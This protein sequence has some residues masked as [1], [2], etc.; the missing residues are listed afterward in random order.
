MRDEALTLLGN[1]P[2]PNTV[3]WY[4]NKIEQTAGIKLSGITCV[5]K[6]IDLNYSFDKEKLNDLDF[7]KQVLEDITK[8][9]YDCLPF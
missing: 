7:L 6:D 9:G 4:K 8:N 5:W 2:L 3:E 1:N